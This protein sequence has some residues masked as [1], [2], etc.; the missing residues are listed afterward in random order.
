[1]RVSVSHLNILAMRRYEPQIWSAITARAMGMI[2][3]QMGIGTSRF[4]PAA[5]APMSAPALIEFAITRANT[6]I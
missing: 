5:I 6:V 1:M 4:I 3:D 2:R